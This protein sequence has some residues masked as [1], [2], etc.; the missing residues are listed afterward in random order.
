MTWHRHP[1]FADVVQREFWQD[2]MLV[3]QRVQ[4]VEPIVD[5]NT[6]ERNETGGW[7]AG[8]KMR[9]AASIPASVYYDWIVQW[10]KEGLL[11][12]MT[13]PDFSALANDLCLKRVKDG[14]YSKFRV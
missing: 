13:H 5:A 3:R 10:Q 2:D 12:D 4:D 8:R 14:D 7:A 11:P 1:N 6:R 9:K